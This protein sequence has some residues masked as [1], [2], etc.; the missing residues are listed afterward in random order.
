MSLKRGR[1]D[2]L[3]KLRGTRSR[4]E[5]ALELGITPQM[6]GMI[7]RDQR[8]PSLDLAKRIADYYGVSVEV[9]FFNQNGHETFLRNHTA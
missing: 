2:A 1:R 9:I 8:N 6:L 4:R 7:E 5:V 3:I